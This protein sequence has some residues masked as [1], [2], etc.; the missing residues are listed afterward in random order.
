MRGNRTLRK[1]TIHKKC[2]FIYQFY[3]NK[4]SMNLTT[5]IQSSL[6]ELLTKNIEYDMEANLFDF[7][8]LK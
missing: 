4:Y 2:N 1:L 6:N 3:L 7:D 5:K 8:E